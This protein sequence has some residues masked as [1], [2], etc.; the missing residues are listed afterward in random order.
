MRNIL[1]LVILHMSNCNHLTS[2]YE[3]I[4]IYT[5]KEPKLLGQS[6]NEKS[7]VDSHAK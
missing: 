7:S 5:E 6:R 4:Q 3:N 1:I 2:T